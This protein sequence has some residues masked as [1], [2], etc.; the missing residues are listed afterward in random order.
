MVIEL[1]AARILAPSMGVSLYTWTSIIGVILAAIALGNYLGGR[2]ADKYDSLVLLVIIFF[3]GVLATLAILPLSKLVPS[4][5]WFKEL[6]VMLNYTLRV[7]CIFLIPAVILSMVSPLTIKLTLSDLSRTGSVAGSIYAWS[8]AGSIIGTFVTGFFFILLF[9]TRMTIWLV[10]AVLFILGIA[11]LFSFKIPDRWKLSFRNITIWALSFLVV[12][13]SLLLFFMRDSWQKE[14]TSES[15]YYTID[16]V[17]FS[18]DGDATTSAKVV[19]VLVL[20]HLI[21]SYINPDDP[22]DLRYSYLELFKWL[23]KYYMGNNQSPAVLHLGG[24]GYSFPRY[25][26]AVYPDSSNDVI[27]I[28]PEVTRIV[29]QELALPKE[30]KI[31]TYNQDARIYLTTH[32]VKEKYDIVIGDVFNDLSTPYH[33]TTVEFIE[34]VKSGMAPDGLYLINL[35]DNY[36]NG[37]YMPAFINTLKHVF[38]HVYLFSHEKSYQTESRSTFVVAATDRPIDLSDFQQFISNTQEF[39]V[40]IYSVDEKELENYLS[41]RNPKF[42]TDDYAPTDILIAPVFQRRAEQR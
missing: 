16:V 41:V 22:T 18:Y 12:I 31:Q 17:T 2:I 37:K 42:L 39:A 38:R 21:H 11:I 27:E 24:G 26:E 5:E 23:V 32:D 13:S 28:D 33:L 9:G 10:A 6:P 3:A 40:R 20:D 29:Y 19:H 35:I 8:T 14:Y 34:L 36:S 4:I 7:C 25:M 15:N 1:T 30:T